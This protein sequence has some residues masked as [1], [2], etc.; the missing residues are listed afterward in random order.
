VTGGSG[1]EFGE[2]TDSDGP[3]EGGPGSD[4]ITITGNTDGGDVVFRLL[5]V[6]EFTPK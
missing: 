6:L 2:L 3:G 1:G 4:S 5:G